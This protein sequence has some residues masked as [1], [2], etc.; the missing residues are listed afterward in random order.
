MRWLL[1]DVDW[2]LGNNRIHCSSGASRHANGLAFERPDQDDYA[3]RLVHRSRLCL[4]L[5]GF[6]SGSD[7]S[8]DFPSSASIS[9]MVGSVPLSC[10]GSFS[11]CRNSAMPIGV[12]VFLS[13]YSTTSFF[14]DL[15]RMRP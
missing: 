15:Q 7:G 3:K 13:A 5:H 11:R 12:A 4:L 8:A 9:S 1:V 14:F 6:G 2:S 10:S